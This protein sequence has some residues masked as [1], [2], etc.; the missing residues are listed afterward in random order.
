MKM[1]VLLFFIMVVVFIVDI[2]VGKIVVDFFEGLFFDVQDFV[3]F[4]FL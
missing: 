4:W 2:K 3:V 1:V